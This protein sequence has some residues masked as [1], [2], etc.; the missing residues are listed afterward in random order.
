MLHIVAAPEDDA[1]PPPAHSEGM[2]QQVERVCQGGLATWQLR[3]SQR[4]MAESLDAP[5]PLKDVAEACQLS[6]SQLVRAF[7]TSVG[8]TPHQWL[9]N[10]RLDRAKV[11]LDGGHPLVDIAAACGFSDQSHFTRTFTRRLGIAPGAWRR[12][13]RKPA[14]SLPALVAPWAMSSDYAVSA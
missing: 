1:P 9:I 4:R 14:R 6:V 5:I 2:E 13:T 3:L 12:S 11:L 7:R 8:L 10:H